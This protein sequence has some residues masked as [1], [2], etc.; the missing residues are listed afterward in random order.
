M[1]YFY[2]VAELV[3]FIYRIPQKIKEDNVILITF[4]IGKLYELPNRRCNNY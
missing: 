2:I 3:F 4:V 1:Y